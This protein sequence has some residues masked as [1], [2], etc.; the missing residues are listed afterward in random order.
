ME[1]GEKEKYVRNIA[2]LSN[3]RTNSSS[4]I[5]IAFVIAHR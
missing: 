4:R 1:E 2:G 5:C 3:N